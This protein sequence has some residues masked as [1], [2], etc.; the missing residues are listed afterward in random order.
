M[1][2]RLLLG[3]LAAVLIALTIAVV[4]TI[5]LPRPATASATP[6]PLAFDETAAIEHF[7][8]AIRIA[9]PS[10]LNQPLDSATFLRLRETLQQAFPKVFAQ[11]QSEVIGGGAL[12]LTWKGSDTTLAP[13]ILMGHMDVVPVDEAALSQW[14]HPPYDGV[15]ADGY[16]WGR[17]TLDDKST[18]LANLEAAEALL[19]AGFVPKRSILFAFGDDE[20]IGGHDG[21][22]KIVETL[23]A[24]GVHAEFVLDEGGSVTHNILPGVAGDVALIGIAEKGY[25]SLRLSVHSAGGHSSMPPPQSAI[26]ILSAG[27]ARLEAQPMPRRIT[28]VG[29]QMFDAIAPLQSFPQRLILSN[30]WLFG[31][32][33]L[34]ILDSTPSGAATLRTTTAVTVFNG[35]VKD[36]VLPTDA[37]AVVNF[38]ILPGDTVAR[39]RQHV[40]NAL[41]DPRIEINL[42]DPSGA[43]NPSPVSST[44]S[45]GFKALVATTQ[46]IFPNTTVAPY[47]VLGA[48]DSAH[49]EPLTRDIYRFSPVRLDSR[50]LERIHGIDERLSVEGYL[51]AVRFMAELMRNS[52][53]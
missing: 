29:A 33:L 21:A 6:A 24:R 26:G 42:L 10:Q 49:Y 11:L 40:Q 45:I 27:L 9:T 7:A 8:A 17:G 36:N 22:A 52:A 12:L 50:D 32:L 2:K 44:Q 48:T 1:I 46:E 34:R 30:R 51:R 41:D 15:V 3:L 5:N 28:S 53:G 13:I 16:V 35:G 37:N 39:V 4:H 18:V 23:Q 14:T 31:P 20:E 43:K 38:R 25:V 19:N 47:L